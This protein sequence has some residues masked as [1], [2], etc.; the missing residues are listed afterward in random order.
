MNA[1]MMGGMAAATR[2]R[3]SERRRAQGRDAIRQPDLSQ[4]KTP[5]RSAGS[6]AA[7]ASACKPKQPA[8]VA[9]WL[10][11]T[12]ER[13]RTVRWPIPEVKPCTAQLPAAR[14]SR[15]STDP[16]TPPNLLNQPKGLSMAKIARVSLQLAMKSVLVS[17][18][19]QSAHLP[20][21]RPRET[22]SERRY[23][24]CEV[25]KRSRQELPTAKRP[26]F[27][28]DN[29]PASGST[30]GP[31]LPARAAG[32]V[33]VSLYFPAICG[34]FDR[35]TRNPTS[36]IYGACIGETARKPIACVFGQSSGGAA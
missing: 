8:H 9:R 21:T 13:A 20:Q 1:R 3:R 22:V 29:S 18:S 33:K 35:S 36:S 32:R 16:N 27:G 10:V 17:D 2:R 31:V 11:A 30:S 5:A 25:D 7:T 26:F 23:T 6:S 12:A 4:V 24:L 15:A 14:G 34:R 19:L 28:S